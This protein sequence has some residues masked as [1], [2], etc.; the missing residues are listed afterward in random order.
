MAHPC[1]TVKMGKLDDEEACVDGDC[2]V[3]GVEGLRVVDMSVVPFVP[4]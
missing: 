1:G 4:K 3:K 2:K